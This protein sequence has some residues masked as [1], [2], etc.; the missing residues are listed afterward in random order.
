M[1]RHASSR[2]VYLSSK[3]TC[4][5]SGSLTGK[6]EVFARYINYVL[7]VVF[8]LVKKKKMFY[9]NVKLDLGLAVIMNRLDLVGVGSITRISYV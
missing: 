1:G 3:H 6:R 2:L 4:F 8:L 9:G 7:V 5:F